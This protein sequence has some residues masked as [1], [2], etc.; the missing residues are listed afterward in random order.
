MSKKVLTCPNTTVRFIR[1]LKTNLTHSSN[2]PDTDLKQVLD[3]IKSEDVE[4]YTPVY[5]LPF[6]HHYLPVDHTEPA[7]SCVVSEFLQIS[8]SN[9][10]VDYDALLRE[11][12]ELTKKCAGLELLEAMSLLTAE[13]LQVDF[14]IL[15]NSLVRNL[16]DHNL[17]V[18]PDFSV[19]Y[20]TVA[21]F[22]LHYADSK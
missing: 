4:L 19:P 20:G 15:S 8:R 13:A 12:L 5:I 2:S 21:K 11:S 22:L 1:H 3:L 17:E 10:S 6:I 7:E 16:L 14:L 18:F 9:L